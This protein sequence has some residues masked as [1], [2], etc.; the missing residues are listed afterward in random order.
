M[1]R[2]L[3]FLRNTSIDSRFL[4]SRRQL[5]A[6]RTGSVA[7]VTRKVPVVNV[8]VLDV[9]EEWDGKFLYKLMLIKVSISIE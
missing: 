5:R 4:P 3:K 6:T 8:Q 9:Q 1:Q 7:F 2:M